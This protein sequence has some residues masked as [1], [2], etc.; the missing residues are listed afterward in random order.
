M[1]LPRSNGQIEQ[2]LLNEMAHP[3]KDSEMSRGIN[4]EGGEVLDDLL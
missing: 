3:P 4:V 1:M 2:G